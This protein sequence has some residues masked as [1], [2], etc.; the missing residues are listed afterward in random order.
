MAKK[1]CEYTSQLLGTTTV[2][3]KSTGT[4]S[5][6]GKGMLPEKSY[7]TNTTVTQRD[8]MTPDEVRQLAHNR[9]IVISGNYPPMLIQSM[10][11]FQQS[12]LVKLADLPVQKPSQTGSEASPHTETTNTTSHDQ[13]QPAEEWP[14]I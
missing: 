7:T 13:E 10:P 3:V 2:D 12:A 4:I 5:K 8:L 14:T 11:Y 6:D 1:E 9:L